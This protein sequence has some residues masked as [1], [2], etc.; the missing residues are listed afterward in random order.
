MW[1]ALELMSQ[2]KKRK[3][4]E[5]LVK[6]K[7]GE[8]EAGSFKALVNSWVSEFTWIEKEDF[9]DQKNISAKSILKY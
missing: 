7:I 6:Q 8:R 3:E 5:K 2:W 9:E 1:E 4:K